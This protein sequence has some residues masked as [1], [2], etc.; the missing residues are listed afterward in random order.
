VDF[1]RR[2]S[3]KLPGQRRPA[4]LFYRH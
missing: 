1:S 2:G 4:S 3:L